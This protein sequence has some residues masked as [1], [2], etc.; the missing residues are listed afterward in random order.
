M[1]S[2]FEPAGAQAAATSA[3]WG[4]IASSFQQADAQLVGI[5]GQ[6]TDLQRAVVAGE[7]WMDADVAKR[8]VD[9]CEQAIVEINESLRGAR[10]LARRRKFGENEDGRAAARRFAEAGQEYLV[11][12]E[13]ARTVIENMAATYRAAGRTVVEAD[14]AGQQSFPGAFA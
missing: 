3:G 11:M 10:Q 1:A 2:S 7:L 9:R 12:L 14:V 6:Q 5:N 8:A 13:K 4:A